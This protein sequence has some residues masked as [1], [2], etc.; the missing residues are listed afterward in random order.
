MASIGIEWVNQYHG[1]AS[2][3]ANNDDNA[4]GFYR[5]L[6]GVE[7]FDWGD[8]FAWDE[9]FE[10]SGVG[11]P[12]AGT[13][14]VWADDVDIVFFSGHGSRT[15]LLFGDA[16]HDD[17]RAGNTE[18]QLGDINLEWIAFDG[19]QALDWDSGA[20]W[21]RWGWPVFHGLHMIV[22]FHTICYDRK[23]RG[24]KFAERLNAGWTVRDAWIRACIESEGADVWWAYLRAD[25]DGTDTFNDH[26]WGKG[27]TSADP[28]D[29]TTLFYLN[30][31]C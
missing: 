27:A 31:S 26:W 6:D 2:D 13:D 14:Q 29:P 9:D 11:S 22:G 19:C 5:K 8:D 30:G 18:M 20:V 25:A 4:R 21:N 17:G 10:Q 28:D 1:R 23:D 3:L 7:T 24:E 15:S 12:A 16:K